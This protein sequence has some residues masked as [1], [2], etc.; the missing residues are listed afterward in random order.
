MKERTRRINSLINLGDVE[1]EPTG[2]PLCPY[3]N[4]GRVIRKE[5]IE[6]QIW[7]LGKEPITART[8]RY[9]CQVCGRSFIHYPRGVSRLSPYSDRLWALACLLWYLGL[10]VE[11]TAKVMRA[12]TGR[13]VSPSG[14]YKRLV[15][16]GFNLEERLRRRKKDCPVVHIDQG[17][18]RI[19]GKS[20][21]FNIA[22]SP[23]GDVVGLEFLPD[24][25]EETFR[26]ILKEVKRKT[27][28][29]VVVGDFHSS[30]E[31]GT[32]GAGMLFWGCW[33]HFLRLL[34]RRIRKEKDP[35]IIDI[36]WA[37]TLPWPELEDEFCEAGIRAPPGYT[38]DI[39]FW[40]SD[41]IGLLRTG[42][43]LGYHPELITNNA[44]ER[45]ILRTKM[46]Y[47]S[48]RGFS[49]KR[50][51]YSALLITQAFGEALEHG[52]LDMKTLFS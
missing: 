10:S 13:R 29:K 11:N 25:T 38:K 37:A 1:A 8:K 16:L 4:R 2:K 48:I 41:T 9:A 23:D 5:W 14:V 34:F 45:A 46:R 40:L 15:M 21:G 12:I 32:E 33:F 50:G 27:R 24:E 17:Y 42:K 43:H 19:R 7:D 49:S 3:C 52:R 6:R 36:L 31:G 18:I 20:W 44:A 22:V 30:H 26:N 47:K 35:T 39:L 28:S 51:A